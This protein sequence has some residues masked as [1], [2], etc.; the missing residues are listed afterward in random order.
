MY[1]QLDLFNKLPALPRSN[2]EA[3]HGPAR[4]ERNTVYCDCGRAMTPFQSY[5]YRCAVCD[6]TCSAESVTEQ[7]TLAEVVR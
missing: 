1:I 6:K 4:A 7:L 5:L 3:D 2:A